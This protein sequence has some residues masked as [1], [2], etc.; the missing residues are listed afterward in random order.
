M[1]G[2][3]LAKAHEDVEV[4]PRTGIGGPQMGAIREYRRVRQQ[5]HATRGEHGCEKASE[6]CESSHSLAVYDARDSTAKNQTPAS[7]GGPPPYLDN[8]IALSSG[9]RVEPLSLFRVTG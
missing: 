8:T 1:S 5:G 4:G 2:D 7:L 3:V 9:S 6:A